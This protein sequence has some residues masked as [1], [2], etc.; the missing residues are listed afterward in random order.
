MSAAVSPIKA[1]VGDLFEKPTFVPFIRSNLQ[2][3]VDK[4][5]TFVSNH[6]EHQR[7]GEEYIGRLNGYMKHY[8]DKLTIMR[9]K[10]PHFSA[11]WCV[12][13]GDLAGLKYLV[14]NCEDVNQQ[15]SHGKTALH[16][17]IEG[18]KQEFAQILLNH[19]QIILGLKTQDDKTVLDLA[20]RHTLKIIDSES[21]SGPINAAQI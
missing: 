17:A 13:A 4:I 5:K 9:A 2:I 18:S 10:N 8:Q 19:P 14:W 1:I 16:L 21:K 3:T 20:L 7:E 6:P 15:D 11:I 12:R